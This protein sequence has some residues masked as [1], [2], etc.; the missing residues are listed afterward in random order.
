M[1]TPVVDFVVYKVGGTN[2]FAGSSVNYTITASNAGPS[3]ATS[4]VVQDTLPAGATFQSASG[5]FTIA[6]NVVTWSN[7]TLLPGAVATFNLT[8]LA[9]PSVS[10]F[11]NIASGFTRPL[12]RT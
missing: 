10:L 6:G 2:V 1:L 7:L 12:I 4:A 9:S 3:T 8:L 11:V 5:T